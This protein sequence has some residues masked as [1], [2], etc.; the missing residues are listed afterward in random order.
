MYI[1]NSNYSLEKVTC[2]K[3]Y[4]FGCCALDL[5]DELQKAKKK[6]EQIWIGGGG[7]TKGKCCTMACH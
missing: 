7:N 6:I 4:L 1:Y 5:R 3:Y 2:L